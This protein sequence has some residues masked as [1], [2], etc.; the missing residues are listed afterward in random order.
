MRNPKR[1]DFRTL[2]HT[3][4]E[5][6]ADYVRWA[7]Y[8]QSTEGIKWNVRAIDEKVIPLRPGEMAVIL[9]RPGHAKTS[10]MAYLALAEARRIERRGTRNTECVV[11]V[12][13]E[14]SSEELTKM[15]LAPADA[16]YSITDLAWGRVPLDIVKQQATQLAKFPPIWIVGHGIE[17]AKRGRRAPLMTPEAVYGAIETMESDFGIRPTL[18]LLD[19]VQRIPIPSVR[20]KVEVVTEAVKAANDLG[21]RIGVPLFV[22]AQARQEVDRRN[23]RMPTASD[24][25]WA[26]AIGQDADKVFALMRPVEYV[27]PSE[28]GVAQYSFSD[29]R[30]FAITDTLLIMKMWK[31]RG[32]RSNYTWP[33]YF[34]PANLKM[35]LME[36]D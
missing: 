4:A 28:V 7:E 36:A 9:G 32:D 17:R 15:F 30:A 23:D 12:T 1:D 6:A 26:S 31:Q 5:L 2:V 19:Y 13:W 18:L 3:P 16:S 34:D 29:G 21:L 8:I 24:I 35:G 27:N 11:F 33:L 25:Q 20:S 10:I 22:G 14:E